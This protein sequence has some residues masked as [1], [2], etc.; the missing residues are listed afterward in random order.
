MNV[1]FF[2]DIKSTYRNG[3]SSLDVQSH[4]IQQKHLLLLFYTYKS[5]SSAL[6]F[7]WISILK[8][9]KVFLED[10]EMMEV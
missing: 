1:Y 3:A 8:G 4:N 9:T 6:P 7:S 10:W 5:K 2:W